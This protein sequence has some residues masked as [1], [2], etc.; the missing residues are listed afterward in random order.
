[1]RSASE[2]DCVHQVHPMTNPVI[3]QS[4]TLALVI[5]TN[6]REF[7]RQTNSGE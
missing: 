4:Q 2:V 3:E 7:D 6:L 5:E 1:M